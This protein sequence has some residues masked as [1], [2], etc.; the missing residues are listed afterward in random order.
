MKIAELEEQQRIN[1]INNLRE[2]WL[3]LGDTMANTFSQMGGDLNKVGSTMQKIMAVMRIIQQMQASTDMYKSG[4]ISK[5]GNIINQI[6]GFL[7]AFGTGVS[8]SVQNGSNSTTVN[9]NMGN[10]T[11][12]KVMI[13]NSR[14]IN[15][16]KVQLGVA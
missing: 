12:N 16:R 8:K 15:N 10:E 6:T 2:A 4:D 13:N 5:E 3:G 7:G 14:Q 11:V 1:R 9:V